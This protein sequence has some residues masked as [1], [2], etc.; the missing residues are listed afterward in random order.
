MTT[1]ALKTISERS[2]KK[3]GGKNPIRV[4]LMAVALPLIILAAWWLI[5]AGSTN[6][7]NPPLSLIAEKFI[8]TWFSGDSFTDTRF[9]NDVIPSLLRILAG[10]ALALFFGVAIGIPVGS[11]KKLRATVEPVLEFF[12]AIPPPVLVPI[13]MLFMGIGD[14]MKVA[15]IAIGCVWPILLNTVEGVRGIDSVQK[16][17]A[18]S[19][20]FTPL[21]KLF[22]LTLP[23]ASPQIITGARQSL[24]L[25]I[26]LMVI[27]EMFAASDGLG[28][29]I[30]QFQRSFAVPEMWGGVL[31][32][33]ILGVLLALAF[34]VFER[35]ILKWY[36]GYLNTQRGG[37]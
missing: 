3:R 34:R 37:A 25:G 33:G 31:L 7:L 12:R 27:S 23:A 32:L 4:V 15:V 11:S 2:K 21:G 8:P 5:S 36:Y 10:F 9:W 19:Y 17:I 30:V 20:R 22:K 13:F 29:S 28:F 14:G 16:D 1:T 35:I 26:I 6:Y 18:R 24:S